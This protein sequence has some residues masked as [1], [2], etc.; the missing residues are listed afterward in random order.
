MKRS[1]L[2]SSCL[3]LMLAAGC[4]NNTVRLQYPVDNPAVVVPAAAPK[5]CVVR[6]AQAWGGDR[7]VGSRSDGSDFVPDSDVQDWITHSLAVALN[8]Q[9]LNANTAYS[10]EAAR[11]AGCANILTGEIQQVR[12]TEKSMTEYESAMRVSLRLETPKSGVW[13]NSFSSGLSRTVVPLSSVPENLLA[14]SLKDITDA[15]A[16]AVKEK[17]QP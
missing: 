16:K 6:L 13:R 9:G 10:E 14:E 4:A 12:L 15:M 5:I 8:R 7:A 17:L 1:I 2:F 3:C 11:A